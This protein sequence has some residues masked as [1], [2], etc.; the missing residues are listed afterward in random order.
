MTDKTI[1]GMQR[2]ELIQLYQDTIANANKINAILEHAEG[3]NNDIN[4]ASSKILNEND[5]YLS[6]IKHAHKESEEHLSGIKR[7]YQEIFTDSEERASVKKQLSEM[8]NDLNKHN[9]GFKQASNEFLG[10]VEENE[11]GVKVTKPGALE[12]IK[13]ELI[14]LEKKISQELISGVTTISLSKNFKEKA[15]EYKKSRKYWQWLLMAILMLS[16]TYS[17][18]FIDTIEGNL[19]E[20]VINSIPHI[21]V[22]SFLI[23]LIIFTG[24]RSAESKK[25][26]EAYTHKAVISQSF[27][28]YKESIDSLDDGDTELLKIHMSNLLT[29]ISQDSGA[30]LSS[31]GESHPAVE[32][33]KSLTK[34]D[35]H[36]Q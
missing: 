25:L 15:D 5:G 3:A 24:N 1:K 26:E 9:E 29:A 16:A 13:N 14:E 27:V 34:N 22:F 30:F 12:K 28:G 6:T 10:S 4:S 32:A 35:N 18:I 33:A 7:F 21:P 20:V 19:E 36:Q 31:K 17:F 8:I 11:N 23:W 2:A